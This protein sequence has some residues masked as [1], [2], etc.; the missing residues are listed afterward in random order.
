MAI[1]DSI[2]DLYNV[3]YVSSNYL[4]NQMCQASNGGYIRPIFNRFIKIYSGDTVE[5]PLVMLHVY[6]SSSVLNNIDE[7]TYGVFPLLYGPRDLLGVNNVVA[8]SISTG[9]SKILSTSYGKWG[10]INCRVKDR[11]GTITC[12]FSGCRGMLFNNVGRLLLYATKV[13]V[14][15]DEGNFR[16]SFY[17]VYIDNS[18]FVLDTPLNKVIKRTVMKN[19]IDYHLSTWGTTNQVTISSLDHVVERVQECDLDFTIDGVNG[20]LAA[21]VVGN[22]I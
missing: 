3:E 1:A 13:Y 4:D 11:S 7:D 5:I 9:I 22:L 8:S 10:I 2:R 19:L 21:E 6:E 16:H 18:V 14:R 15:D 12:E 20:S 17:K